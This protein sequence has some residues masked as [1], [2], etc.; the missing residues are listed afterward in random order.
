MSKEIF[1]KD[2]R[3]TIRSKRDL[4]N[5]LFELLQEKNLDDITVQ[6]ITDRALISKTTFYNNFNDK[7]ELL[8]FL[9][10]RSADELLEK[11]ELFADSDSQVSREA[12]FYEAIK[13]VVDFL[14]ETALPFKKMIGNDKSRTLY[15]SLTSMIE[16]VFH[17]L[18]E[19]NQNILN[20]EDLNND[21]AIYYY[22]GAY[23]N[24]IYKKLANASHDS[25]IDKDKIVKEIYKLSKPLQE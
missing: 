5:A 23:A 15:W 17:T 10:R 21:V 22:A 16:S 1:K 9:L 12:I 13:I 3:R 8:T 25:R 19:D 20:K 24:L 18:L 11:I 14:V 6:D 2:D 7:S 4:A